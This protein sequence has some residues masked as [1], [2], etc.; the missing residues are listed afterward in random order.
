MRYIKTYELYNTSTGHALDYDVGDTVVCVDDKKA[1]IPPFT[2]S[3]TPLI[4][5]KKYKVLKIY[6]LIEDKFLKNKFMRVDVENLETG[7]ISKG[8]ES[9]RFKS[10]V[11][12]DADKYNL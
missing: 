1:G 10:E 9:T 7:K 4:E 8:W 11:E 6:K 12:F 5:G 2:T 3:K